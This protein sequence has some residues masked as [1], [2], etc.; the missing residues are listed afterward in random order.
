[1]IMS[2]EPVTASRLIVVLAAN[3]SLLFGT[4]IGGGLMYPEVLPP[5]PFGDPVERISR[6]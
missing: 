4:I 5:M 3:L 6:I 2:R 1:M